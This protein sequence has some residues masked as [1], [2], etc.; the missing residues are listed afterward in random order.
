MVGLPDVGVRESRDRV[1]SAIRNSGFEFPAHRITVNLALNSIR[2]R[3]TARHGGTTDDPRLEAALVEKRPGFAD[4]ARKATDREV[5]L[6]KMIVSLRPGARQG[7][8]F[9]VEYQPYFI[10]IVQDDFKLRSAADRKA[11][12]VELPKNMKVSINQVYPTALPLETFPPRLLKKLP[13]LPPE[14]E[15]RLVGHDL[16][17]R[18]VKGNVIVDVLRNVVATIPS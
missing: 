10:K 18:D 16:I 9:A 5:A 1:R 4:P 12:I 7:D 17:L 15:Y 14:L 3:K 2:S 8:I 6:G 13:D 11:I